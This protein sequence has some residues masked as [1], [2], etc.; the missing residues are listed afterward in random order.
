MDISSFLSSDFPYFYK[1]FLVGYF[2]GSIPFGLIL[3]K[4]FGYGDIRK[5][6]SGNIGTTNVLRTG[7]K[8]LAAATLLLDIGKAAIPAYILMATNT[9]ITHT[10]E[11]MGH[12]I[13]LTFGLSAILGHCFPIWL[14]FNGGKGVATALG[15]LL[16][17]VP[18]AGLIACLCW[19]TTAKVTKI[20]SLSALIAIAIAPIAVYLIYGSGPTI[21][22]TLITLLVWIRHIENIKRLLKG[23]EARIGPKKKQEEKGEPVSKS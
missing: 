17:A 15:T 12:I 19:I 22:C 21:I 10:P 23:E 7:N 6:G 11:N 9:G 4:L 1:I 13:G 18:Y 20:S 3:A 8:A 5:I 14:K 2:L 16:A